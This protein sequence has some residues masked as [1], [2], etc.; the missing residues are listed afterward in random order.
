MNADAGAAV[1]SGGAV[2]VVA[3]VVVTVNEGDATSRETELDVP[4]A[5]NKP[6]ASNTPSDAVRDMTDTRA[7]LPE[8]TPRGANPPTLDEMDQP[9]RFD[10]A[11]LWAS[12]GVRLMRYGGVTIVSSTIGL[13]TYAIG[14]LVFDWPALAANFLSVCVST[15]PAY[16]LNRQWVWERDSGGHSVSREV[17]PFWIMTLIG[18]AVSTTAIGIM[19]TFTDNKIVLLLTQVA[20]FGALWLVKFAFLEK[21]MWKAEHPGRT[22]ESV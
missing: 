12:Y 13:T 14:L 16:Y 2:V 10:V 20:S 8:D 15:P 22:S 21:V 18:F 1:V 9:G 3:V 5:D 6:M 7:V 17:G 4:Q 11:R 19:D